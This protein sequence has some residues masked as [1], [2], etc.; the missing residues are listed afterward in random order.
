MRSHTLREDP[1]W[2]VER[3]KDEYRILHFLYEPFRYPY[4]SPV[5]VASGRAASA[6]FFST[7]TKG[8]CKG[9]GECRALA[10]AT[11]DIGIDLATC[12]DN[13]FFITP[14]MVG[15]A[16]GGEYYKNVTWATDTRTWIWATLRATYAQRGCVRAT[17]YG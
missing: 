13:T 5:K 11:R 10:L 3:I 6:L 4:P 7:D 15:V 8:A 12:S 2:K 14:A 9:N 16:D 17:A 1:W